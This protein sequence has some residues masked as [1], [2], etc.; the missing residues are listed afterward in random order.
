LFYEKSDKEE[1]KTLFKIPIHMAPV[2]VAIFP[3]MNKEELPEIAKNIYNDL[4]KEFAC[5]YDSAGSIGKRYLREGESGTPFCI[6][7]DYDSAKNKDVTVRFRDTEEQ[8]RI[9]IDK[10]KD[11]LRKLL[12]KEI[13]FSKI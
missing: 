9:K 8:K 3:L 13:E 11:T 6:T 1:G 7:V 5:R 10:L 12:D 2:K 4:Q